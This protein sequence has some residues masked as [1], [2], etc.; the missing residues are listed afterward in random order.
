[1]QGEIGEAAYKA[2]RAIEQKESI[3]VGVNEFVEDGHSTLPI[4]T[5]SDQVELD[6]VERLKKFRASRKSGWKSALRKLDAGTRSNE[7][8]MPLIVDAVRDDCTVGE[9]VSTLKK[10]FG[11][12][13]DV[14]FRA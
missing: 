9:I 4:T 5:I 1:M 14:S 2:Q 7:N 13:T 10:T 11:E 12:H 3:V 6:Q 8:L